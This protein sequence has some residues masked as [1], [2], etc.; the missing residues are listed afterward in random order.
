MTKGHKI[1]MLIREREKLRAKWK[2]N[3]KECF[4]L[5]CDLDRATTALMKATGLEA[6]L[7][8]PPS[9]L[10]ERAQGISGRSS[11][12]KGPGSGYRGVASPVSATRGL[13]LLVVQRSLE[14]EAGRE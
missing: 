14:S 7:D 2:A 11:S 1:E 8:P 10:R 12:E 4:K 3:Q 5:Q 6:L 13:R 9:V